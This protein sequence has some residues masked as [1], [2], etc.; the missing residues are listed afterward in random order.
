MAPR[1]ADRSRRRAP[2][3][4]AALAALVVAVL[5]L[6]GGWVTGGL[7]TNDFTLSMVLTAAWVGLVGLACLALVLRR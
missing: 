3:S 6:G 2:A 5:L 7:I 1:P 4:V